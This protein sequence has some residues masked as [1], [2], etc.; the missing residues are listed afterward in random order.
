MEDSQ[1]ISHIKVTKCGSKFK[2]GALLTEL[3]LEKNEPINSRHADVPKG[4]LLEK[5]A[6]ARL[7]KIPTGVYPAQAGPE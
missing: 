4:S 6:S 5:S 7:Y 2:E 3:G 1:F